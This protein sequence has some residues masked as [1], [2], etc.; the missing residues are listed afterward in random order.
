MDR[1]FI[2]QCV[3]TVYAALFQAREYPLKSSE[4]R[5]PGGIGAI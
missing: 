5:Y 4:G 2:I 1:Q 3:S